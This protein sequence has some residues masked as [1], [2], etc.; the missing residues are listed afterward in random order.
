MVEGEMVKE[1]SQTLISDICYETLEYQ[2]RLCGFWHLSCD[3]SCDQSCYKSFEQS[4]SQSCD[5][6]CDRVWML[7]WWHWTSDSKPAF[8]H[9]RYYLSVPCRNS[10][11]TCLLGTELG[12]EGIPLPDKLYDAPWWSKTLKT[13]RSHRG[14][15][16]WMP[17][18]G[19]KKHGPEGQKQMSPAWFEWKHRM[20]WHRRESK[21]HIFYILYF[22]IFVYQ[23]V[24]II[25]LPTFLCV[26]DLFICRG[27]I[28]TKI[29]S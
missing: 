27:E 14:D 19:A 4:C 9:G 17:G 6:S 3:Q 13:P 26:Y 16:G 20:E 2:L 24:I 12:Q 25:N 18:M 22:L 5:Q 23:Y 8:I 7:A 15:T 11:S 29:G 10:S 21:Q 28:V 1:R